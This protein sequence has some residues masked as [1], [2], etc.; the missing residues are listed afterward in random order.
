MKKAYMI[1][2]TAC[3]SLAA[4]AQ[5]RPDTAVLLRLPADPSNVARFK[6]KLVEL[7]LQNPD[8][9]QYDDRKEIAKYETRIAKAQW[10]NHLT[11]A[12]NLN[13]FTIKNSSANANTNFYPRYNFGVMLPLGHLISIPNEV[14][15]AKA[16]GKLAQKQQES[17]ALVIK[18]RVLQAYEDYAANKQLMELH[19]PILEDA[20]LHYNQ[21]E[22][23]FRAGDNSVPLD[24]YKEAYRQYNAEMVQKVQLERNLRQS[25]L[26]LEGIVGMT[27]EDVMRLL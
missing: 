23:K 6:Q 2:L 13:E 21:A 8:V 11:A 12:G 25:K 3:I 24:V 10:L 14:K 4:H 27:L 15:R 22:E 5:Q 20:L 1:L 18:A 7:A 19:L 26:V 17:E 9:R 16:S